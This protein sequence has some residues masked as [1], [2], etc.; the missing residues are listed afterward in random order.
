MLKT[1]G[2]GS[3]N[4]VSLNQNPEKGTLMEQISTSGRFWL[5]AVEHM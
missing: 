5:D 3:E 4:K 2:S 1:R